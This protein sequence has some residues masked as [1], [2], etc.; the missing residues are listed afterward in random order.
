MKRWFSRPYSQLEAPAAAKSL[1][2]EL[3]QLLK[4]KADAVLLQEFSQAGK[5]R[6]REIQIQA[7]IQAL[8]QEATP[9]FIK[10]EAYPCS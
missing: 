9:D 2:K 10:P 1:N 3:R 8:I 7:E 4:D 6:E 5:M